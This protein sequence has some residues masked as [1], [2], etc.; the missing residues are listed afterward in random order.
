[1][2]GIVEKGWKTRTERGPVEMVFTDGRRL[3][4][5]T[6]ISS[7]DDWWETPIGRMNFGRV[8][9]GPVRHF[10]EYSD[11]RRG[12]TIP[13]TLIATEAARMSEKRDKRHWLLKWLLG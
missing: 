10:V 13:E 8:H 5:E 6:E 11:G 3:V 12:M 9:I 7:Y 2:D 1:M 4:T